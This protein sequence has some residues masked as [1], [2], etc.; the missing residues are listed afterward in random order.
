M[1]PFGVRTIRLSLGGGRR[2]EAVDFGAALARSRGVGGCHARRIDIAALRLVHDAADAVE[3]DQRVQLLR[4]LP[5]DLVEV[6]LVAARLG[7][8]QPKLVLAGLGLG[9]IERTRLEDAAILAGLRLQ[10]LVQSHGVVLQ[11]ADVGI[12]VQPMDV[13]RRVPCRARGQFVSFEQHHI[14][15]A[16]LGKM[17]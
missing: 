16:K 8:L 7:L 12:V 6:H 10:L 13:G 17:V 2:R 11:P 1:S 4:L 5:A 14:R 3:V 15:P 9:E